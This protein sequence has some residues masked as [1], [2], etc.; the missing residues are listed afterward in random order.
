MCI[1]TKSLK[2][3]SVRIIVLPGPIYRG[4]VLA[5]EIHRPDFEGLVNRREKEFVAIVTMK[6]RMKQPTL[7]HMHTGLFLD[8]QLVV[9]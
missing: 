6:M 9:H 3:C 5:S 7:G 8:Y 2:T 4:R 1:L